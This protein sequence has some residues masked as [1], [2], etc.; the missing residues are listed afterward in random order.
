MGGPSCPRPACFLKGCTSKGARGIPL[1]PASPCAKENRLCRA[2]LFAVAGA[3]ACDYS[4]STA[5]CCGALC[6]SAR[7]PRSAS[8]P[9]PPPGGNGVSHCPLASLATRAK[10][11][12]HSVLGDRAVSQG[13]DGF[14]WS[15]PMKPQGPGR[16][17]T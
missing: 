1:L 14:L 5:G 10:A 8:T 6:A 17:N 3:P 2:C 13:I 12:Q 16:S 4:C 7:V 11:H 9:M 15:T